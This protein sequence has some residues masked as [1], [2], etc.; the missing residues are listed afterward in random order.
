MTVLACGTDVIILSS[1]TPDLRTKTVK[2][3]KMVS[4]RNYA[5]LVLICFSTIDEFLLFFNV[6]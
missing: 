4:E 2:M 3:G 5:N 1:E 6:I